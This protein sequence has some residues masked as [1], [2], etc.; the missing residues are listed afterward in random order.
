MKQPS[1]LIFLLTMAISAVKAQCPVSISAGGPTTFC[2]GGSVG[3]TATTG[4]GYTWQ[5]KK[6]GTAIS[7]ATAQTW[8]ATSSGSYTVQVAA[9]GGCTAVSNA[10]PVTVTLDNVIITAN[11]FTGIGCLNGNVNLSVNTSGLTYQWKLNGNNI[12]GATSMNYTGTQP[13]IYTCQVSN[14]TCT[15]VTGGLSVQTQVA[16]IS[17]FDPTIFCTG[18]ATLS[19]SINF[20]TAGGASTC[21]WKN[22]GVNIPGAT[23]GFYN[24][25]S[26]GQYSCVVYDAGFCNAPT[27]PSNTISVQAGVPPQISVT[28]T[29]GAWPVSL[30]NGQTVDLQVNDVSTGQVWP[31]GVVDWQKDGFPISPFPGGNYLMG[32][33]ESGIYNA[34]I[35]T[36]CGISFAQMGLPVISLIPGVSPYVTSNGI[37]ADCYSVYLYVEPGSISFAS[38]QWK[39]NGISIPGAVYFSYQATQSGT[40]TCEV[41]NSCGTMLAVGQNLNPLVIS[42]TG[43]VAQI[44][45]QGSTTICSGQSI[46]LDATAAGANGYQWKKNNVNIP[47]ATGAT[48]S[49]SSAGSYTVNVNS[50]NCG[51]VTS[52]PVNITVNPS[53]SPSISANGPLSFCNGGQVLLSSSTG[54]AAYQW[55]K[56]GNNIPGATTASYTASSSGTFKVVKTNNYGCSGTSAA[57]T[58]AV[59]SNPSATVTAQGPTV[60]CSGDSVEL[61]APLNTTYSYQW[62]RN[63]VNLTGGTS[64]K[65]QAKLSGNY[66]VKVTNPKGCTSISNVI[67]VSVPCRFGEQVPEETEAFRVFAYP[68]PSAGEFA[69]ECLHC[70]ETPVF[71]KIFDS[72]GRQ[73]KEEPILVDKNRWMISG[74]EPGVY[75]VLVIQHRNTGMLKLIRL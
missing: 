60:F 46:L 16:T 1:L 33:T 11:G 73:V 64:N 54:G 30:C 28:A 36:T 59:Y 4:I 40:Y 68:N 9:T 29:N 22:N 26:S 41:S 7:G 38:Y 31:G 5:W 63:N 56:N 10:I 34:L 45:P 50:P 8:S 21:Q 12:N 71:I 55:K 72:M 32:V 61:K 27:A 15:A 67:S 65:F 74:T 17:T 14:G 42:I 52:P 2:K 44:T 48:Y 35:T 23:S 24:A 18:S 20:G 3:L 69:L 39:R 37:L 25:G 62:K 6:N 47:G 75:F 43:P 19:V 57:S 66:K 49:T 58:V 70:D 51:L 13:G 53:P